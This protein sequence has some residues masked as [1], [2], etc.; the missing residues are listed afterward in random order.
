MVSNRCYLSA[1]THFIWAFIAPVIVIISINIIFFCMVAK[2]IY[3]HKR[4]NTEKSKI[5]QSCS[6]LRSAITLV[7]IMGLT[8][9]VGILLTCKPEVAP[10]AYFYTFMV[11][12]QGTFIFLLLVLFS[13]SVR[14]AYLKTWRETVNG[15]DLL[16]KHF[17]NRLSSIEKV[18]HK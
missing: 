16:S 15:S 12:F 13:Q 4:R 3:N 11:A 5:G 6:W 10:L 2:V 8:W 14:Q 18:K 9:I 1:K 7:V 17:G